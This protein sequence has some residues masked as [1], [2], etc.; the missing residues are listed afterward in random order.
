MHTSHNDLYFGAEEVYANGSSQ[1]KV[2]M[3][4]TILSYYML[5]G[6]RRN[7]GELTYIRMVG[8]FV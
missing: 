5:I 8:I 1:L 7:A 6:A 2:M 3:N 4:T